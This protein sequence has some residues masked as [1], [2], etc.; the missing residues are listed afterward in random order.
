MKA[1]IAQ[2]KGAKVSPPI[3]TD[4]CEA[5]NNPACVEITANDSLAYY[6]AWPFCLMIWANTNRPNPFT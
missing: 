3:Q 1:E 4:Q 5:I 2:V 6:T